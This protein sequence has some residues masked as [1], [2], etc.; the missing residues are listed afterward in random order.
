MTNRK[1][2]NN[3]KSEPSG[4]FIY[5]DPKHG[6]V[7]Y[8]IFK[9]NSYVLTKSD[10]PSYTKFSLLKIMSLLA[11]FLLVEFLEMDIWK[12]TIIGLF[13]FISLEA[14]SRITFIYKLPVIENYKPIKKE[15]MYESMAKNMSMLRIVVT[16]FIALA[17]SILIIVYAKTQGFSGM[18]LYA[19][20]ILSLIMF[21]LFIYGIIAIFVKGKK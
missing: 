9:R 12:A 11:I 5:H 18:N 4:L 7:F 2:S 21:I 10:Y 3:K 19:T 13:L 1:Y 14:I 8:D 15:K 17:T 20:Y 16:T 6:I